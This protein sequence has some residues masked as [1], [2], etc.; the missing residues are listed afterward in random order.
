MFVGSDSKIYCSVCYPQQKPLPPSVDTRSILAG[1]GKGCP[2]CGGRVFEAERMTVAAG[3]FH[4]S[5]FSCETCRQQLN[6]SNFASEGS[7][8]F[9]P[10]C[11]KKTVETARAKSVGPAD[12]ATIKG[13]SG[14]NCGRCGG[15]V[16]Q[17]ELVQTRR[18]RRFHRSC[19][20]CHHCKAGLLASTLQEAG[21]EGEVYC[22][23]CY[24]VLFGHRRARSVGPSQAAVK[25]GPGEAACLGC[26]FKVF[27]AE[28]VGVVGGCYHE[29]CFKCGA[30]HRLLDSTTANTGRAGKILCKKCL[31]RESRTTP[32]LNQVFV[33]AFVDTNT[34]P[35]A[36][37]DPDM[38]VRCGGK[39]FLAERRAARSGNYH[40]AC[41]TCQTCGRLL[42]LS[43]ACDGEEGE[44][45]CGS[46]YSRK[47]SLTHSRPAPVL[48]PPPAPSSCAR[49][50][51]AVVQAEEVVTTGGAR[52]HRRCADTR[53]AN[54]LPLSS[55]KAGQT[56]ESCARCGGKIFEPE[57]LKT[58]YATF[59]RKCFSCKV[60]SKLLES[61]L[62]DVLSGPDKDIYCRKCHKEKFEKET[63]V[64][65]SDPK[66]IVALDGKGCPRCHGK[67][68][69]AEQI[70]EKGRN[71][72]VG[73]FT[74]KTCKKPLSNKLQVCV[75]S[76]E[77][78]YCK[79]CYK[80][81]QLQ[82][83][84]RGPSGVDTAAIKGEEK[85][86]C[87]RC[88]GKVFEAE[89]MK[90]KSRVF[91]QK[92]FSCKLCQHS[93]SY[94]SMYCDR[95]G[96]I[97]CKACYLKTYFVG[98]PNHYLDTSRGEAVEGG[99]GVE[100]DPSGCV[101]CGVSVFQAERVVTR[102]GL[103]H[104]SCLAC[105]HCGRALHTS[106][107]CEGEGG[108]F[109]RHC[110]SVLHGP[111]SRSQSRG[112]VDLAQFQAGEEDPNKCRG[113]QGKIFQPEKLSTCFGSFHSPCFKCSKCERNLVATIDKACMR[114]E[115]I[116]CK[117]C[118]NKEKSISKKEGND[119][120]GI[121]TYAKSIVDCQAIPASEDDP[122]R[123]LRCA[124]KVFDA[125]RMS[126]KSGQFHKKCFSCFECR[127]PLD[128]TTAADSALGEVFCLACYDK[129][130]GPRSLVVE[131]ENRYKTDTIRPSNGESGCPRCGFAVFNAEKVEVR[132]RS[133]HARCAR[134]LSCNSL[135][136]SLN[137][138]AGKDG[139]ILCTGCYTRTYGGASYR[140]AQTQNW[141]NGLPPG[142]APQTYT[143]VANIK[144]A[145]GE[146][147][148]H[149]CSGVVYEAEKVI[150]S[151]KLVFHKS[152]FSCKLCSAA[153]DVMKLTI[154]PDQEIFCKPCYKDVMEASK[155]S[156][157]TATD[158]IRASQDD[159]SGC[160]RCGG[161]VYD[162]EKIS[163]KHK[164]FHKNCISC[165]I[166]KHKLEA[167]TYVEGPKE[168]VYC[169]G[170]F[171]KM[172]K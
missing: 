117:Q 112:P 15:L 52:Y 38:C 108:V 48:L 135:L 83:P 99:E 128:Y 54:T 100:G 18:G 153:L 107:L 123:C 168:E 44:V 42:D 31:V 84:V 133:Y 74:C 158:T 67:V 59:H 151:S 17:L 28:R 41:F 130:F 34:I 95:E 29:S 32:E 69:T 169:K 5:C 50:G 171:I 23:A 65:F 159:Q 152:C 120:D 93:L 129:N 55:I 70:V 106:N 101:R 167:S 111:R 147:G 79:N 51:G 16:F 40:A 85:E 118:F 102:A 58:K 57:R 33:R 49:C 145:Q 39:V 137:L 139:A 149:R 98:R 76:D 46:C 160:P 27:Q 161:V 26:G 22:K 63:A 45:M 125:E 121:L 20:T 109:R 89:K 143:D 73:C 127:R 115:L 78:V 141:V 68:Y 154:G 21:D 156:S 9:C 138:C 47:Y 77:E 87:P 72:H 162:V 43:S 170:V 132:G 12:L 37:D 36:E 150:V 81:Q 56:E 103:Y 119:E 82:S 144:P 66:S 61:S 116:L 35:A 172:I 1:E 97:F 134:C 148:C 96:E 122:N 2:R 104:S 30:C 8:L 92:C 10:G 91:H 60:C 13:S 110:Y 157:H 114:N 86:S 146:A 163:T 142:P 53:P 11:F 166:C 140:G 165:L 25:A 164:V 88:H 124:G 64:A 62:H 80:H 24:A 71:F 155:I 90:T 105:S 126:M 4:R 6:Y 3:T 136:N 94:N 7:R 75:G 19:L 113:C 14:E 131:D